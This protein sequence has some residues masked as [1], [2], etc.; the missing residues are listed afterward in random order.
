L[1]VCT[2]GD[3]LDEV[4]SSSAEKEEGAVTFDPWQFHLRLKDTRDFRLPQGKYSLYRENI[5]EALRQHL[6]AFNK[7][8]ELDK[9]IV[10]FGTTSD[11][12]LSFQK[13]FEITMGC[14]EVFEQFKPGQLVIQTR[15]P[16]VIS[17]LPILKNLG[18]RAAVSIP[19]ESTSEEAIKRYSPGQPRI[20]E[21]IVA[22]S[23]LRRQGVKVNLSVSP[24]LPYGDFYRDS[25]S[26]AEL[27]ETY[28]DY[29]SFG[30]L[31][32][33]KGNEER[34]LRQ[35]SLARKLASDRKFHWLRP[36]S[37]RNIFRAL[38]VIA[39]EKMVLPTAEGSKKNQLDLFAA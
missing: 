28:A 34:Q 7:Q 20:S 37:F 29:V 39:P 31:A 13:K 6:S 14:L 26:F 15:S 35:L 36:Y 33:G 30:S 9:T 10:Y 5:K 27:L 12:F 11:A 32:Y 8:G 25:W 1:Q 16:M 18:D 22:A 23:G 38:S 4:S 19:I 24:V 3:S 21:R 17:A 2:D